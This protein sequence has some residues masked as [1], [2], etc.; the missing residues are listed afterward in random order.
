MDA[1]DNKLVITTEPKT[2]YF[3]LAKNVDN[4]LKHKFDSIIQHNELLAEHAIKKEIRQIF[5]NTENSKA[6]EPHEFILN[7]SLKKFD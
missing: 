3:D 2:I 5:R 1:G 4:D 7:L 6:N